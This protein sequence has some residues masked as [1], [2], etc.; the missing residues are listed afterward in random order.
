MK[1]F[2]SVFIRLLLGIGWTVAL[3]GAQAIEVDSASF[4]K[5]NKLPKNTAPSELTFGTECIKPEQTVSLMAIGDVL[6][7]DALQKWASNQAEGF[8]AVM[9]GL[10][11]LLSA[12]DVTVANLEGPSAEG[13]LSTGSLVSAPTSLYDGLVYRG[14]PLFNYHP[15]IVGDLKRLG[16]D[17]LQTANNHAL[18]RQSI[19]VDR[20]IEEIAA[21]GLTSVGTRHRFWRGRDW[22]AVQK[23]HKE[24]RNFN[25]AFLSCSFGTNGI[26]DLYKQVLLC[27]E[28][29]ELI[30]SVIRELH[31]NADIH[32]VVVMP[33]WGQ[34]YQAQPEAAQM[35]LAREMAQAGAT[36]IIGTH[37]HVVQPMEILK[38]TDGREVPVVYSLGNFV[39]YQIGMPR[40]ASLI[41]MLALT[42]DARGKLVPRKVAWIPI[43]MK[44][45]ASFS[46]QAIDRLPAPQVEATRAHLLKTYS[47]KNLHPAKLPLWAENSCKE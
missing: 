4:E 2:L 5:V 22:Y 15:S 38:T 42:P 9:Q 11:D 32:A 35:A 12:A 26:P 20:T 44:T 14:Y 3:F 8:H 33:H 24:G 43:Q 39:S 31:A 34:E 29:K 1:L 21:Q 37:P 45:G 13:V 40:L 19:G 23:V 30:L 7:H 18:D 10:Q 6:L 36:A 28:N 47:A 27:Y 41:Y 17:V 16:I 46:I 25:F